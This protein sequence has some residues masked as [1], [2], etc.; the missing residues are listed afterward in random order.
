MTTTLTPLPSERPVHIP[1]CY[2]VTVNG[3]VVDTVATWHAADHI[4]D[5]YQKRGIHAKIVTVD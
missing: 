1:F 2:F 3:E 5:W 4:A